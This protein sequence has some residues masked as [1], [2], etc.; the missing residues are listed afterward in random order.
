MARLQL[1][2]TM[3]FATASENHHRVLIIRAIL[4]AIGSISLTA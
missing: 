2:N 3:K 4:I 1:K